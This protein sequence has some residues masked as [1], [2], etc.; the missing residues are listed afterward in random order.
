MVRDT[1]KQVAEAMH[2][3]RAF[4]LVATKEVMVGAYNVYGQSLFA[5]MK[6]MQS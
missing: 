1:R 6:G 3:R 4:S 2:Q 5:K